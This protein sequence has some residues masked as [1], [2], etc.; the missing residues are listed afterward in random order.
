MQT[1][2]DQPGIILASREQSPDKQSL[3]KQR[4][5]GQSQVKQ[6][7]DRQSLYKQ[8]LDGQSQDGQWLDGPPLLRNSSITTSF[9]QTSMNRDAESREGDGEDPLAPGPDVRYL[10]T[11]G[12]MVAVREL[13][14][15]ALTGDS[16]TAPVAGPQLYPLELALEHDDPTTDPEDLC[17]LG[18]WQ[19]LRIMS[20]MTPRASGEIDD[21]GRCLRDLRELADRLPRDQMAFALTAVAMGAWHSAVRHCPRCGTRLMRLRAGWVQRCP[22]DK[23]LHF[24][25]TDP[26]VI[27]A[28][29]DPKDRLL[30]AQGATFRAPRA[31]SVL[32]GYVEPGETAES[33]VAREA[34]EEV[35]VEVA[36]VEYI[37]SQP[38]PFPGSLM[39]GFR[40]WTSTCVDNDDLVLQEGEIASAA[41]YTREELAEAIQHKRITLPGRASISRPLIEDWFGGPLPY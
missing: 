17:Y 24:P 30:L 41:W 16:D 2:S 36:E 20:A 40:A 6:S 39:L 10:P 4:L 11:S 13:D 27:M 9:M 28:I 1:T 38:W 15:R 34:A 3:D 22:E 8:R 37:G 29:R 21:P 35:G 33:A 18:R 23:S 25:R 7:R 19:G 31:H 5:D 14:S 26:A 12:T 32:A